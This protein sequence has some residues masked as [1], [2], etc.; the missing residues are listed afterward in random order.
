MY[1]P[2]KILLPSRSNGKMASSL[3]GYDGSLHMYEYH[4]IWWMSRLT[5]MYQAVM[6]FPYLY[7]LHSFIQCCEISVLSYNV[8]RL[9]TVLSYRHY[10]MYIILSNLMCI[11]LFS[12][13]CTS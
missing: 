4:N 9:D 6:W 8:N 5:L 3:V 2:L 10:T 1:I 11:T 13:G 12:G 7:V